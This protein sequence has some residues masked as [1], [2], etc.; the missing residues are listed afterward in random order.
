MTSE[1]LEHRLRRVLADAASQLPVQTPSPASV[2]AAVQPARRTLRPDRGTKPAWVPSLGG[3]LT[4]VAVLVAGGIGVGSIAL[5]AHGG[6]A[7]RPAARTSRPVREDHLAGGKTALLA[8]VRR[9]HGHPIV[10]TV[11]ASWCEPCRKDLRVVAAAARTYAP[12]VAFL[13]IDVDDTRRDADHFLHTHLLSFASYQAGAVGQ[14]LAR[15]DL[16]PLL[17]RPLIGIPTTIFISP[18]GRVSEH[19]GPFLSRV[20]VDQAMNGNVLVGDPA[21]NVLLGESVFYPYQPA[22]SRP[23]RASLNSATAA[24]AKEHF[25]LKVALIG[26]RIDLGIIPQLFGKPQAYARYLDVEISFDATAAARRDEER[27]RRRGSPRRR[28]RRRGQAL[29]TNRRHSQRPRGCR[30]LGSHE[31]LGSCRSPP[32]LIGHAPTGLPIPATGAPVGT[33]PVRVGDA[34]GRGAGTRH[35]G[36]VS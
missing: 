28:D 11:W 36:T 23:L 19:I 34:D 16:R 10:I 25:P 26:S 15:L 35:S 18:T 27:L 6:S 17:R 30:A 21:S 33:C 22:T 24:A 13:G 20:S 7:N 4:L 9:L 1:H 29:Q 2:M 8:T 3:S 32:S 5:L 31:A 12:R 14:Q